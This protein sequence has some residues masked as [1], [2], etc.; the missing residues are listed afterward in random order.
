MIAFIHAETLTG[1]SAH[2]AKVPGYLELNNQVT[3]T[4]FI[5]CMFISTFRL[6]GK[7]GWL[8]VLGSTIFV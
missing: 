6:K 4:V 5:S 8:L 3:F 7:V 1:D 2:L